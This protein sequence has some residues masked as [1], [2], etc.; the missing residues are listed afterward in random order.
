MLCPTN[1]ITAPTSTTTAVVPTPP[2]EEEMVGRAA[3]PNTP[4]ISRIM[5]VKPS[6]VCMAESAKSIHPTDAPTNAMTSI[7]IIRTG[8]KN[9]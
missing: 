2:R 8:P 7:A 5:V 3:N 4:A 9:P 6:S 1:T